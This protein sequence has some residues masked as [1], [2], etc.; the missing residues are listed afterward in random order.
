M[1][2]LVDR[3]IIRPDATRASTVAFAPLQ[4]LRM[5]VAAIID[6]IAGRRRR[7]EALDAFER[8]DARILSDIGIDR[9]AV[10]LAECNKACKHL[11]DA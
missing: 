5:A 6:R 4:H 1:T 7:L 10:T 11:A 2:T 8:I 9:I 3:G